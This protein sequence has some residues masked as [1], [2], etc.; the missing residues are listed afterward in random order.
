MEKE[1]VFWIDC[2]KAI[3]ICLV[4]IGHIS[5]KLNNYIYQFHMA[6]FF[7]ISGYCVNWFRCSKKQLI[8]ERFFSLVL[9]TIVIFL[10]GTCGMWL[11][12]KTNIYNIFFSENS[13]IGVPKML[14]EFFL[15]GN[16]YVW[17]MGATWFLITLFQIVVLHAFLLY[18]L[19]IHKIINKILY[20]IIVLV[21][22]II[23]FYYIQWEGRDIG[24]GMLAIGQL[25][26]GIGVLCRQ[27]QFSKNLSE[28][29]NRVFI[30]I[31]GILCCTL[32]MWRLS[33]V[34]NITVDYP[35]GEFN[36]IVLNVLA[37]LNGILFVYFLSKILEIC[38]KNRKCILRIVNYVGKNTIG[39]VYFHFLMFK[40]CI[41]ILMLCGVVDITY[42]KNF[43]PSPEEIGWRFLWL[44]LPISVFGSI[45]IWKICNL[46]FLGRC[47][48]GGEREL[49]RSW[50][51]YIRNLKIVNNIKERVR[52]Y[53]KFLLKSL[54][55]KFSNIE[56]DEKCVLTL[57]F[58]MYLAVGTQI[59]R[60]GII[61][62][63]ELQAYLS[64][65]T[66]FIRMLSDMIKNEIR[67][68][69]P[70]RIIAALNS[71]CDFIFRNA[72]LN[73]LV[74]VLIIGFALVVFSYLIIEL[75]DN[76]RLAYIC[77]GLILTFLPLSFEHGA[78]NAYIGLVV[79]PLSELCIAFVFW[80]KYLKSNKKSFLVGSLLFWVLA[81]GGYEFVVTYTPVF[82]ILYF[83]CRKKEKRGFRDLYKNVLLHVIFGCIY[84][85]GTFLLQKIIVVGYEGL[86][87]NLSSLSAIW[88]VEKILCLSA[89]PGYFLFNDKYIYLTCFYTGLPGYN[90]AEIFNRS[91]A[92]SFENIFKMIF[93]DPK[94]IRDIIKLISENLININIFIVII[95]CAFLFIS[96]LSR[97]KNRVDNSIITKMEK[98]LLLRKHITV[99]FCLVAY[100]FLPQL[101]NAISKLYQETTTE[102]F[103]TWLPVSIFIFFTSCLSLAYILNFCF[104]KWRRITILLI[105]CLLLGMGIPVQYMNKIVSDTNHNDFERFLV[106]N[107]LFQT[108]YMS[109][110]ENL[111]I[112][113][114]DLY[115]TRNLLA[116]NDG[117]W[118]SYANI[119]GINNLEVVKEEEGSDKRIYFLEDK[120]FCIVSKE[121][122]VILS[123]VLLQEPILVKVDEELYEVVRDTEEYMYDNGFYCYKYLVKDE[124]LVTVHD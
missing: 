31:S 109:T 112:Y 118:T 13:Y 29:R 121:E 49:Y 28:N 95:A 89:I 97:E 37:A 75:F 96:L 116:V 55:K 86:T 120:Y 8:W 54:K 9:P 123:K 1:R 110:Q 62:N 64:R 67:M 103:F 69:R 102:S 52:T 78:P 15:H 119:C 90:I 27:F 85:G 100:M 36:H 48:L 105:I 88:N 20:G 61:L 39:V 83:W 65:Q 60:Q 24:T 108:D 44:F 34:E 57:L 26:F 80:S 18:F 2:F 79:I 107:D 104:E 124:R 23:G 35:S 115:E 87:I 47:L 76:R 74:Q 58:L 32:I 45:G 30:Y 12:V 21:I 73:R 56:I 81:L 94:G 38:L 91:G 113:A 99:L 7:W 19:N 66:G 17:W 59:I 71:S 106:I 77:A 22:Y 40:F 3:V 98:R 42:M 114:P 4:V 111:I 46:S 41:A 93:I 16:N 6:A 33:L 70:L 63:D 92:I 53:P 82:I 68:G 84:I 43:T 11:L 101:P 72:Y 51:N 14:S 25:Y 5:G 50:Y 122:V 117:Y 10:V